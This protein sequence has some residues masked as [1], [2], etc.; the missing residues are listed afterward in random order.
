MTGK[1]TGSGENSGTRKV[2][3]RRGHR[4]LE[5]LRDRRMRAAEIFVAGR[6][7]VDVAVELEVMVRSRIGALGMV[8]GASDS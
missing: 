3:Q 5:A 8:S 6:R 1:G 2:K 4:D 7:Q